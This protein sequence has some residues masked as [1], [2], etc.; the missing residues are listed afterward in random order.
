VCFPSCLRQGKPYP[1]FSQGFCV[2]E[3]VAAITQ[4]SHAIFIA[5]GHERGKSANSNSPQSGRTR[6][7]F[8]SA[9]NPC[10]RAVHA[11]RRALTQVTTTSSS[12]L[13]KSVNRH[14]Q[15]PNAVRR[16]SA[17]ASRPCQRTRHKPELSVDLNKQEIVRTG[18]FSFPCSFRPVFQ[19]A[20]ELISPMSSFDLATVRKAVE[21]FTPRRPQKFQDLIPAKDVIMELRQ[22]RASYRAI[23]DLLTQHCLPTS[24]TAIA[25]FC[26]QVLGEIVRPRRRPGRKRPPAS[27]PTNGDNPAADLKAESG[28]GGLA[29]PATNSNG[30]EPPPERA[31]GPRIAQ[32]RLLKSPSS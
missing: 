7:L 31:R 8:V 11:R 13:L 6:T 30:D 9:N 17:I 19:F 29:G 22:K 26:H 3:S 32:L 10:P 2:R 20:L 14:S 12:R 1:L 15:R 25:L 28:N 16:Q 24:K 4:D 5:Q 21:E 23:S 18:A 27:V